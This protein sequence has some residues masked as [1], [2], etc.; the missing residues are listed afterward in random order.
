M[1]Q[2]QTFT[3]SLF[4]APCPKVQLLSLLPLLAMLAPVPRP[5]PQIPQFPLFNSPLPPPLPRIPQLPRRRVR[6]V[7]LQVRKVHLPLGHCIPV[8]ARFMAQGRDL[9]RNYRLIVRLGSC[10]ITSKDT[11]FICAIG[12]GLY[13]SVPNAGNPNNSPFCGKKIKALSCTFVSCLIVTNCSASGASVVVTV[14]DRC[15]GCAEYDLDFSPSA[16]D[17]LGSQSSGR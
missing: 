14:V 4:P 2:S 11:D 13:D 6:T 16:F 15:T 5:L 10:G 17:Q 8:R 12:H 1:S 3:Q 9:S 7:T